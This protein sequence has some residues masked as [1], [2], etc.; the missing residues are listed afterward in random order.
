MYTDLNGLCVCCQDTRGI[1]ND[2]NMLYIAIN[3][4]KVSSNNTDAEKSGQA[5]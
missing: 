4:E 3:A 2:R 1:E 5:S